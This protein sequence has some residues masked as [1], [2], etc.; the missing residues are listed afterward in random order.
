MPEDYLE[1][2]RKWWDESAIS[3]HERTYDLGPL[4][5]GGHVLYDIEAG[6]LP[7]LT[8]LRICH[9][10]CHIGSDSL[11]LVRLGAEHVVG[12]DFSPEAI[13]RATSLAE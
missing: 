3:H 11:S 6:E 10:Q 7:D 2:N 12:V 1:V 9:L 5:A 13:A 4:R 8:G